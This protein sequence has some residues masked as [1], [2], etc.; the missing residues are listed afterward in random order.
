[1]WTS[2]NSRSYRL[3][4]CG[5]IC[6][7][8]VILLHTEIPLRFEIG[9]IHL[10]QNALSPLAE[11]VVTCRFE[12]SCS[13]FAL[14]ALDESGF[15]LGNFRIAERLLMCSPVGYLVDVCTLKVRTSTSHGPGLQNNL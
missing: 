15:W 2:G 14:L 7:L 1:M 10:Y 11:R 9:A 8:L 3:L 12:P 5:V 4:I 13:H 6:V